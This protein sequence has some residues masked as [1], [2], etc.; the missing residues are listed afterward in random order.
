VSI[1]VG[2]KTDVMML[3]DAARRGD[4]EAFQSLTE[5][6]RRE[7][8][9]HCYRMLG[10]LHDAEDL[11][12]ETLLRAWRSIDGFEGR[13]SFRSWLYRIA[14]N[15]C[16]NAIASHQSARRMLPETYGPPVEQVTP[17]TGQPPTEIAWLEPY[18]DAALD[19]IPDA[20]PGPDVR[21]DLQESVQL[22]F[23]AAIQHLPPRQRA[24]L[25]LRDVLGWSAAEAATLLDSSV[26]SVNSALQRARATLAKRLPT[27][28]A[29]SLA[30]PDEG[31][32]ALL[33]RY[34][35]AWERTDLDALITLLR[36]EAYLS[37]P[38][39][40]QWFQGRA[41]I[42]AFL[43]WAWRARGP[44]DVWLVPIQANRQ[45]AFAQYHR[46]P[47]RHEWHAH[48][49]WL[50]SIKGGSIAALNGFISAKPFAA[51]GLPTTV[52]L[53]DGPSFADQNTSSAPPQAR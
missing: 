13:A 11:V 14:T 20:A 27:D 41:A 32:R 35:Q 51:F 52:P 43:T 31:Q 21:Y 10:S 49:I 30:A 18:P 23:V 44:G 17:L 53:Q 40:Q 4:Q 9:V 33:D 6:H 46:D 16:L 39:W 24:V 50:P 45:P 22:A 36:E 37:M 1:P 12:Q 42:R 2:D 8:Q 38:P 19:G 48:S 29:E 15:A 47:E 26:P 28:D 5:P 3:L 7:L 25:L 34:V